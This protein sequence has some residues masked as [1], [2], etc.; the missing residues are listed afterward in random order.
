[1]YP[2]FFTFEVTLIFRLGVYR[3][4]KTSLQ[5][6]FMRFVY[7]TFK[8]FIFIFVNIYLW[9]SGKDIKAVALFN[10]FN[11]VAAFLAFFIANRVAYKNLK[12][13]YLFSS[14]SFISLF[15]ITA[16]LQEDVSN[17]SVLI[18]VLG[19]IGDGLFFFNLNLYQANSLNKDQGQKFMSVLGIITKISSIITPI[20]SG[21]IIEKYGFLNML[22]AL[23]FLVF[24][25]VINASMLPNEKVEVLAKFNIKRIFK[26]KGYRNILIPHTLHAPYGQFIIM[27]NSVFLYSFAKSESLMGMLNSSFAIA[28]I[29]LYYLYIKV[30]NYFP[31][32]KIMLL[33]AISLSLAI[34]LLLKPSFSTFII[35]SLS[36]SIGEA[37]FNKPL[38]GIQLY[39]TKKYSDSLDEV[40][41]NIAIRVFLLTT[42]R[43]LFYI[44]TYF[45]YTGNSSNLFKIFIIYSMLSPIVSY[46]LSKEEI[47]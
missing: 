46:V 3:L 40:L 29:I 8:S 12:L 6:I 34:G 10:L 16:I 37:F 25:Q 21:F 27:A 26:N 30:R 22:Y 38:T 4:K 32:K 15:G 33:G 2:V 35:F 47:E 19:G 7:S 18:G 41:G 39:A 23:I 9:Q 44:L 14:L 42:G 17:F 1:M 24:L 5:M 45:F 11:Y 36:V 20:I 31:R 13:N 28:S 43:S